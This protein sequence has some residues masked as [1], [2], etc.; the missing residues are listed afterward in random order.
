MIQQE[1]RLKVCDNSGAKEILCIRVLGGTKKR[2]ARVGDMIVATVKVAS[3]TGVVKRK[4]V[5]K[6]IVVRTRDQIQRKDGSTIVF[7]DNAAVIVADDKTLKGTRVF[8]PV[9]RELRDLGFAKIISL[10]PEVL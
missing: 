4:S 2:Y 8:G 7:D 5:V 9:P 1:S 3:T 10:A 6:A